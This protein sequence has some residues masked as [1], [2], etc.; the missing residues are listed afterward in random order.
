VESIDMFLQ[1]TP[2]LL[3]VISDSIAQK[4]W[5]TAGASAHKLKSTLGFFGM[6]N[7]QALIQGIELSCKA[8][9]LDPA[10]IITKFDQA[11]VLLSANAI[12]L[13]KLK[14]EAKSRL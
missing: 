12:K 1:Q 13:R 4:D 5:A 8:G 6:L 11:K 2:E 14:S 7:T 9:G 3:G 10:D